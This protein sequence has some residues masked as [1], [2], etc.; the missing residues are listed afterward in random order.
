MNSIKEKV[1]EIFSLAW[2]F[3]PLNENRDEE[4]EKPSVEV[5]YLSGPALWVD[6]YENGHNILAGKSVTKHFYIVL[7]PEH[8]E[9][10]YKKINEE[11][12]GVIRYLEKMNGQKVNGN[13]PD[14]YWET[15][16]KGKFDISPEEVP[17]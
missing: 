17:F 13:E 8:V 16:A 5:K 11:L 7:A 2:L 12:D 14:D 1:F 15:I 10:R 9:E 3:S 4:G 6:C